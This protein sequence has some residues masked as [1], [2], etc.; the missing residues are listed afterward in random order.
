MLYDLDL[1]VEV[2]NLDFE[3]LK[4]LMLLLVER[5]EDNCELSISIPGTAEKCEEWEP[6]SCF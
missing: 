1:E 4:F 2:L 6:C 3:F 5:K